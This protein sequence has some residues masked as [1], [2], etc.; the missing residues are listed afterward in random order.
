MDVQEGDR[1]LKCVMCGNPFV[2]T[3]DEQEFFR[4]RELVHDPK[5]CRQCR[6]IVKEKRAARTG[7]IPL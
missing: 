1:I 3:N 7:T 2:F 6:K 5:K 4:H